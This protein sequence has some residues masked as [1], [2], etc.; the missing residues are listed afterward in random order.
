ML[1][2]G[3]H[4]LYRR[5]LVAAPRDARVASWRGTGLRGSWRRATP[6]GGCGAPGRSRRMT[7]M[8]T[9]RPTICMSSLSLFTVYASFCFIIHLSCSFT[10]AFTGHE[11]PLDKNSANTYLYNEKNT[12]ANL[13][14]TDAHRPK[15]GVNKLL[16]YYPSA[17]MHSI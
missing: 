12:Y 17:N 11:M 1:S 15:V 7:T 2:R 14:Y 4:W 9:N 10:H 5:E 16:F 8:T 13:C 6:Y 3:E